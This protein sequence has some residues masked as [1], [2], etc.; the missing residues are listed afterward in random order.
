MESNEVKILPG[1]VGRVLMSVQVHK[2]ESLR[3]KGNWCGLKGFL[4]QFD[5]HWDGWLSPNLFR[6]IQTHGVVCRHPETWVA[7]SRESDPE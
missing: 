2:F 5:Q 4:S 1:S 7:W 6:Q 3:W